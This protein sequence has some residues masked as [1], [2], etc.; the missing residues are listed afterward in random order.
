MLIGY[1][2]ADQFR[3]LCINENEE[4]ENK[5]IVN[6]GQE[7]IAIAGKPTF[8]RDMRDEDR[9]K[10]ILTMLRSKVPQSQIDQMIQDALK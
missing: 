7:F 10:E 9:K 5:E 2:K 8:D 4:M 1:D 3:Q 6:L